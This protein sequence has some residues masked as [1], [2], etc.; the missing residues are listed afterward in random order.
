MG[1]AISASKRLVILML[2]VACFEG[3][4]FTFVFNWMPALKNDFTTPAHGMIFATFM[5]AYMCGS[6][7]FELARRRGAETMHLGQ[8]AFLMGAFGFLMAG[9][10]HSYGIS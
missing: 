8:F 7:V 3:S 1:I 10:A 6:S 4:M 5:M 9:S 2:M